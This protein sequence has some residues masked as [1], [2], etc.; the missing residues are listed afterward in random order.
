MLN[1]EDR[2]HQR[3]LGQVLSALSVNPLCDLY[4]A[5]VKRMPGDNIK[6]KR[7]LLHNAF[8]RTLEMLLQAEDDLTDMEATKG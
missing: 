2:F 5:Y 1:D 8:H 6:S 7:Y 3:E 4:A